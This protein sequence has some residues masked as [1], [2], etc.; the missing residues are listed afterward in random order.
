M[1]DEGMTQSANHPITTFP[2]HARVVV[3]GG[4]IT[5]ASIAYHLTELGVRDVVLVDKGEL[6][7]GTTWHAAGKVTHFHTSP[8]LMRM[9]QYSVALYRRLPAEPGLGGDW[10]EG[11]SL[12]DASRREP[13]R[14]P[15]RPGC[16][17]KAI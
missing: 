2:T 13:P 11:G 3:I 5:G 10:H 9:R 4:G 6:T 12:L 14:V 17:A 7:S 15:L 1:K 16:Q 8:T